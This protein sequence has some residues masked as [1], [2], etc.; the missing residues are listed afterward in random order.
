MATRRSA[1][2]TSW[3]ERHPLR[4][5]LLDRFG[6]PRRSVPV[7]AGDRFGTLARAVTYQQLAGAAATA[8]WTRVET[9]LDNEVNSERILDAGHERLRGCGLSNAKAA[10]LVALAQAEA[11]G[12]LRFQRLGRLDDNAVIEHLVAI[13][14]IGPWTAQM[15]LI[16]ALGREDVWPVSDYGVRAGIAKALSREERHTPAELAR[17]GEDHRPFRTTLAR[18]AWMMVDQGPA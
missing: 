5:D 18:W 4:S 8:I 6:V 11:A 16:S 2:I 17:W 14:G 1:D 7:S 9:C 13:R 10:T 15:F 3:A 12:D